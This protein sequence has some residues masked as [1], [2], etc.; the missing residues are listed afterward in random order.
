[1]DI[2]VE[3]SLFFG[4]RQNLSQKFLDDPISAMKREVKFLALTLVVAAQ[5]R[6]RSAC[7]KGCPHTINYCDYFRAI[8][9]RRRVIDRAPDFAAP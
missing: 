7:L 1:M 3:S 5:V 9:F 8:P 2:I 6:K 4:H